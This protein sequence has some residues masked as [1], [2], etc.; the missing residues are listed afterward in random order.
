MANK[1][2]DFNSY[3]MHFTKNY[4]ILIFIEGFNQMTYSY[5]SYTYL[6]K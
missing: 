3:L 6:G 2:D 4:V 5:I 1:I